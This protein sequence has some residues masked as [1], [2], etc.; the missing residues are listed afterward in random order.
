MTKKKGKKKR[1]PN[2]VSKSRFVPERLLFFRWILAAVY[3]GYEANFR[4]PVVGHQVGLAYAANK[5]QWPDLVPQKTLA[6]IQSTLSQLAKWNYLRRDTRPRG[7][8]GRSTYA[9][10][11]NYWTKHGILNGVEPP[12][13]T[14]STRQEKP[15]GV[16]QIQGRTR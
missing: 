11:P 3:R 6:E 8:Y 13:D 5:Q 15:L 9:Y 10:S 16:F 12:E 1:H 2:H 14:D 4:Q 7:D